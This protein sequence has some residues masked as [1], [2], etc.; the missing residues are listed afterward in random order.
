MRKLV[1]L[2]AALACGSAVADWVKVSAMDDDVGVAYV[3]PSTI[4]KLSGN[5][6]RAWQMG[7]FAKPR[8]KGVLSYA[9]FIEFDCNEAKDR[10]IQSSAFTG[11]LGKGE[12]VESFGEASNWNYVQPG[13]L[14]ERVLKFVCAQ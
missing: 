12:L 14:T 1:F 6:R 11:H 13:T 2:I 4:K 8:E 7:D 10:V 5:V 3:D 9:S